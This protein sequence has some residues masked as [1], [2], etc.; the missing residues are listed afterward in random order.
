M[1]QSGEMSA[2]EM[3]A[4]RNQMDET[5]T[6]LAEKI[7]MLEQQVTSTVQDT[8]QT[9]QGTVQ[10]VG[11]TVESVKHAVGDTVESV[12]HAV[13][14]TVNQVRTTVHDSMHAVG[15]ALSISHHVEKHPWPMMAGAMAVGF[16][17]GYMLLSR[18]ENQRAEDKFRRLAS[19]QGRPPEQQ[20]G[21]FDA[22]GS[23][24]Q[25]MPAPPR[26]ASQASTRDMRHSTESNAFMEWL[27]PASQQVQSLAIG[28]TLGILRDMV[29]KA[30]P[31][32]LESQ[33]HEL[34]DGLTSSLGGQVIRNNLLDQFQTNER[35]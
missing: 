23:R 13:E 6:A 1:D 34:V 27:K 14:E 33:V 25:A 10:S 5:R 26:R 7:G 16:V 18:S 15:E 19:S 31:K 28:A 21:G 3:S 29:S 11:D 32:P 17:G 9:V 22:G 2:S 24:P 20:Y 8:V 12:K 30:V 35:G 4:I